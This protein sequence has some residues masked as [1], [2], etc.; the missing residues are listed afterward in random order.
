MR[1]YALRQTSALTGLGNCIGDRLTAERVVRDLTREHPMLG[2]Y[3][4]PIASQ[5]IQQLGGQLHIPVLMT[6]T[7]LD[8]NHHALA[9]N[10]RCPQMNSLT[11]AH[12]RAI[13]GAE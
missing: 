7:L 4:A 12:A 6:F 2:P 9:V 1:A 11:D 13:H 3:F 8:P 5:Q 10:V